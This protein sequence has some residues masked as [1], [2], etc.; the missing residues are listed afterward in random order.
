MSLFPIKAFLLRPITEVEWLT[1]SRTPATQ[2][3]PFNLWCKDHDNIVLTENPFMRKIG[4]KDDWYCWDPVEAPL[5]TNVVVL[6]FQ[7]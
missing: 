5:M 3:D 7:S 1:L 4:P 2:S 6:V